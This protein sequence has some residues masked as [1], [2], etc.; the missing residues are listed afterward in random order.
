MSGTKI[1]SV[2]INA[3]WYRPWI[4]GGIII[5]SNNNN[6]NK[7]SNHKNSN[8]VINR[9]LVGH[10]GIGRAHKVVIGMKNTNDNNIPFTNENPELIQ[11]NYK[12]AIDLNNDKP[13]TIVQR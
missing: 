11:E 12:F 5:N 3:P 1:Y 13:L 6:I 8:D 10:Q 7:T 2:P 4:N 9:A